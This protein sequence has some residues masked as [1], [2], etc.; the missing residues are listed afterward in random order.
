MCCMNKLFR[1]TSKQTWLTSGCDAQTGAC[2]LSSEFAER[3]TLGA[4]S[5]EGEEMVT[6][7]GEIRGA[8]LGKA[9]IT[10]SSLSGAGAV[11][12]TLG[13]GAPGTKLGI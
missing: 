13:A 8:D 5:W 6:G 11:E 1:E 9:E 4:L 7:P 2:W 12:E 10:P 3:T